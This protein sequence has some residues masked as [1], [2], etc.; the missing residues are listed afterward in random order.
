MPGRCV[1]QFVPP[2]IGFGSVWSETIPPFAKLQT[3]GDST[4]DVQTV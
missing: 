1:H 4:V 2:A 3:A